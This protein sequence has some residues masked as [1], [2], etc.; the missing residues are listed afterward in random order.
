MTV[1]IGF[2]LGGTNIKIGLFDKDKQL[3]RKWSTPTASTK[4]SILVSIYQV[5][6]ANM[7]HLKGI[8]FSVPGFVNNLTGEQYTAG[9]IKDLVGF[10]LKEHIT[11]RY[12]V[13]TVVENDVNCVTL[14]EQIFGNGKNVSNFLALTIG[15][16]VGGGIVI[17]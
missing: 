12:G 2:D 4:E 10:N 8:G 13:E 17:N 16:G 15:T 6:E 9:A 5:I 7:E 3:I 14:A 11:N 1:Y